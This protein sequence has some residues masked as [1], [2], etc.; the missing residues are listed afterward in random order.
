MS[1]MAK[2]MELSPV[3][4]ADVENEME[5]MVSGVLKQAR[6]PTMGRKLIV[7]ASTPGH[8]PGLLWE[9]F[10]VK[11]MPPL[12]VEEQA[13]SIVECVRAGA[14]AIHC[15]QRDPSAPYN[16]DTNAFKSMRPELLAEIFET[17][18]R[19]VD[20]VPLNHA[21]YPR[22]WQEM[23]DTD[24]VTPTRKLL[25]LGK[26]NRYIQGN[27]I[28]A[29]AG[30]YRRKGFLSSFHSAR[31][32]V[33]GIAFLEE[34]H[35][36]PLV[37]CHVDYLT[38]FK[39][40]VMD[41]GVFK[42]RLHMNIEDGK[43]NVD[44]IFADPESYLNIVSS[45]ELVKKLV[46]DCTIGLQTGGRNWLPTTIFGIMLGADLVRIGIEDQFWAYPH[47]DE[48]VKNPADSV[49]KVVQIARML[50]REI[51]TSDEARQI[52]GIKVTSA[53]VGRP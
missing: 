51:A 29:L 6:I 27:V 43:H 22:D 26:G 17:A 49:R 18:Y 41:A 20:F 35:V 23:E 14:A 47:R 38:W 45:L 7:E 48:I 39:N 28:M 8:Y 2:S 44:R 10:G 32:M 33:E 16:Y 34:N 13:A 53:G 25:E 1:G 52:L 9:R 19:E 12:S 3:G 40:S 30:T 36:K 4:R 24:Y 15:H 46:P 5:E 21:W 50:G 31:S 37:A 42:T 11:N